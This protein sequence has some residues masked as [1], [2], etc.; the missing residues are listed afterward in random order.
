MAAVSA[1]TARNWLVQKQVWDALRR[2]GR[3]SVSI[4]SSDFGSPIVYT[5]TSFGSMCGSSGTEP[6]YQWTPDRY[7]KTVNFYEPKKYPTRMSPL[8]FTGFK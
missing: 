6:Y 3:F 2:G 1:M 4:V 5:E 7:P 8:T